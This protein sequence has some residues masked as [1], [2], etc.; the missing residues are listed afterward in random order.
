MRQVILSTVAF[1]HVRDRAQT[2]LA[3][4]GSA[5]VRAALAEVGRAALAVAVPRPTHYF[6]SIP[7]LENA[8]KDQFYEIC[9]NRLC[10]HEVKSILQRLNVELDLYSLF[11]LLCSAVLIESF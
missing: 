1:L 9:Y 6:R 2:E 7:R 5:G 4:L 11:G 3:Q 8:R 10:R